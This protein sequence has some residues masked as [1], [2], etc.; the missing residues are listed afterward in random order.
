MFGKH[1]SVMEELIDKEMRLVS[2][3]QTTIERLKEAERRAGDAFLE[4]DT[5]GP[6][7][8]EVLRFRAEIEAIDRAT[9]TVRERRTDA[10]VEE[11][12]S[13]AARL[14]A[15]MTQKQKEAS[16]LRGKTMKLLQQLSELQDVQ[17]T[18][19]I[20]KVQALDG[21]NFA[22]PKLF[23]LEQDVLDLECRAINLEVSKVPEFGTI[24]LESAT[25]TD[26]VIK[27]VL[28]HRSIG[29]SA[30]EVQRWS[31]AVEAGVRRKR[32][33]GFNNLPRRVRL[34]W[35]ATGIKDSSY[36]YVSGLATKA[37]S[38]Y[39]PADGILP[40]EGIDISSGTFRL[41]A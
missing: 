39:S 2:K 25:S 15:E 24:D 16:E 8:D 3:K 12:K 31:D 41:A 36:I 26:E 28:E 40:A 23:K 32:N 13:E 30:V 38:A 27:A 20:L 14:R 34:E 11:Y 37:Q 33:V 10:I 35:D 7:V 4:N 21:W 18:E 19:Q 9:T 1:E 29:P 6:E 17:F 5:A 22:Q